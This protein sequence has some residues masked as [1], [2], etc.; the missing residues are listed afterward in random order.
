MKQEIMEKLFSDK[1]LTT[2]EIML[3]GASLNDEKPKG[4][5][6]KT[7]LPIYNHTK[8]SIGDACGLTDADFDNINKLIRSQIIDKKDE[9][10]CDSKHIEAME[11]IAAV[12]PLNMRL[13][14]YQYVKMKNALENGGGGIG[15]RLGGH[16]KGG[17]D[18]FL[19]FLRGRGV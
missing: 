4:R 5:K 14:L 12:S 3:V 15:F 6:K 18:D 2:E 16:G 10:N 7:S 19:D 11:K 13:I 17:F 8:I 9:I 1:P